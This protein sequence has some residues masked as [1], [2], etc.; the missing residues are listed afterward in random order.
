[1]T[2]EGDPPL[3]K[4]VLIPVTR[5]WLEENARKQVAYAK[6]RAQWTA[7][8]PVEPEPEPDASPI[9][10]RRPR[11]GPIHDKRQTRLEL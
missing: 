1:M 5:Q 7:P 9:G 6:K 4:P 10:M 3:R 2:T 11:R 8:L